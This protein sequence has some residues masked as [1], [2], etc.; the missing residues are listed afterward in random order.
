VASVVEQPGTALEPGVQAVMQERLDQDFSHVRV[1]TDSAAA[2]TAREVGAQAYTV[3]EHI[4]FDTGRYA[5][6]VD[7]G[8]RLLAHELTHVTQQRA[9][10]LRQAAEPGAAEDELE[11]EAR[12]GERAAVE[13]RRAGSDYADEPILGGDLPHPSDEE[14]AELIGASAEGESEATEVGQPEE[15]AATTPAAP[16]LLAIP[17]AGGRARR[18]RRV[19]QKDKPK[20]KRIVVD[21]DKQT[22]TALE[23]G[24]PVKTMPISSGKPG[25]VTTKGHFKI[26]EKD[27]DH[28]SSTYGKCGSKSGKRDV[29]GGAGSCK[30]GEKYEG[31]PMPYFQRFNGGQGLHKGM[32]PGHPDSHGCVR[33]SEDNAK[34]VWDWAENGTPVDVGPAAASKKPAAPK[35]TPPTAKKK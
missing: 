35:K 28:K 21:L 2:E 11:R 34:W 9:G 19:A 26:Y 24:K 31:A 7:A 8:R 17:A 33:L 25:H 12:S 20:E 32:L 1:H 16:G 30:K 3:G 14:L 5:P 10:L 18:P 13:E 29:S 27:K 15:S 6:S 23:D 22:A 4:A